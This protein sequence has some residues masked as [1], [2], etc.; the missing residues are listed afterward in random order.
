MQR[1]PE[2]GPRRPRHSS[3]IGGPSRRPMW[4]IVRLCAPRRAGSTATIAPEHRPAALGVGYGEECTSSPGG[5]APQ[6]TSSQAA[7]PEHTPSRGVSLGDTPS[8]GMSLAIFARPSPARGNRCGGRT[9]DLCAAVACARNQMRETWRSLRCRRLRS[10]SDAVGALAISALPSPALG[11]RCGCRTG[12]LFAAVACA[13][14][15]MQGAHWRSLRCGNSKMVWPR[16][17][18]S[19]V[20]F[21]V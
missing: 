12:D 21:S 6:P 3:I 11:I 1:E 8:N 14:N 9:G 13:R 5:R 16:K 4:L 7:P 19:G 10:E 15:Q 20:G 2:L 18:I 17:A